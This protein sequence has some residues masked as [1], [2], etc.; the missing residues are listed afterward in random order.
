MIFYKGFRVIGSANKL[1]LDEGLES[2]EKEPK[3][4][5]SLFLQVSA[6]ADND[7]EGWIEKARVFTVPDKLIDTIANTGVVNMQYSAARINEAPVE[8]ELA[9]GERFKIGILC[10]AIATNL[11]GVYVYS[12][13]E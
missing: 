9:V 13:R 10:G 3:T 1:V 5:I 11:I 2:T 4:L 8:V 12:V 7:V 6:Y